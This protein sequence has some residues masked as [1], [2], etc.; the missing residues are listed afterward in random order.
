VKYL[1]FGVVVTLDAGQAVALNDA[2]R[3]VAA[4]NFF[5]PMRSWLDALVFEATPLTDAM[6]VPNDFTGAVDHVHAPS[7]LLTA[8][9][10]PLADGRIIAP[11]C[12][13][14]YYHIGITCGAHQPAV[15]DS[16]VI[17]NGVPISAHG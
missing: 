3:I 11:I 7:D 12:D 13:R 4:V 10:A 14:H 9:I 17:A 16:G 6:P 8:P 1:V 15:A 2:A 5:K